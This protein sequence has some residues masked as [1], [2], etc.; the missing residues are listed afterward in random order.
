MSRRATSGIT[1]TIALPEIAASPAGD[2]RVAA[3]FMQQI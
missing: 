2:K 3:V 1:P